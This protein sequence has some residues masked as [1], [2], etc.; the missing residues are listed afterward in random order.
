LALGAILV[1]SWLAAGTASAATPQLYVASGDG[2]S[3]AFKVEGAKTYVLGLDAMVYCSETEPQN[4]SKPG[5]RAF[6]PNPKPMREGP[7]GGLTASE[8]RGDGFGSTE[9]VVDAVP[10]G[11]KLVGHFEYVFSELSSHCQTGG[12]FGTRPEVTFEAVPYV[13]V[14]GSIPAPPFAETPVAVYYAS[15]GPLE[16]FFTVFRSVFGLRGTVA[17]GCHG[18]TR[19]HPPRRGPLASEV[20][21]THFAAGGAFDRKLRSLGPGGLTAIHEAVT[22]TGTVG[23]ASISGTYFNR[24]GFRPGKGP[25]RVCHT[26]PLPFRAVRYLPAAG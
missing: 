6:F 25:K 8:G 2:Y 24:I 13:P 14:D 7:M 4:L 18:S 3:V 20:L 1:A 22:L 16:A 10:E 9:A 15:E 17:S 12:Y 26:G 11:G 5:L 23:D 21:I 19:K